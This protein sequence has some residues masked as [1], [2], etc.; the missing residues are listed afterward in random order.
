MIIYY[1]L[2]IINKFSIKD[3]KIVSNIVATKPHSAYARFTF[4]SKRCYNYFMRAVLNI[5]KNL[6][7]L[8]KSIKELFMK[9]LFNGYEC[10]LMVR[11][12]FELPARYDGLEKS[13]E[14][15]QIT[16]MKIAKVGAIRNRTYQ[17]TEADL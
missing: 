13:N 16:N 2:F 11:E 15:H 9:S 5:E 3:I 6:L 7:P 14:K 12:Q 10:K 4:G 17:K 8:K 1:D